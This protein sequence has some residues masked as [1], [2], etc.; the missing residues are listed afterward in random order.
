M[1]VAREEGWQVMT[2]DRLRRRVR[3]A[4]VAVALGAAG[5]GGGY[6]VASRSSRRRPVR[7]ARRSRVR[8]VGRRS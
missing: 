2:F 7:V 3:L 1:R 8:A 4:G 6:L 5:A